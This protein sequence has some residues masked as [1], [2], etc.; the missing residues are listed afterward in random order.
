[1]SVKVR[2]IRPSIRHVDPSFGTDCP[3]FSTIRQNCPSSVKNSRKVCVAD[4]EI[5]SQD[6]FGM[7]CLTFVKLV[8]VGL[9]NMCLTAADCDCDCEMRKRGRR[10]ES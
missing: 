6:D 3:S 8:R 7:D 10:T 4:I 9:N 1:M 2:H 5:E